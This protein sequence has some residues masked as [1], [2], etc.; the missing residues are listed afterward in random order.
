[1][2]PAS[3]LSLFAVDMN[4]VA[5]ADLDGLLCGPAQLTRRNRCARVSVLVAPGWRVDALV[6]ELAA[7]GLAAG[8]GPAGSGVVEGGLVS[9]RTDFTE[10]LAALAVRWSGGT[11]KAVPSG[12]RLDGARLRLWCLAAGEPGEP[13]HSWQLR[14][15][16]HDPDCWGPV[17]SALATAGLPAALVG[18]RGAG[19]AYRL[20]GARRLVRLAELVGAPPDGTPPGQWP[21]GPQ[22]VPAVDSAPPGDS[23]PLR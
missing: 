9:V 12:L 16:T 15:G 4:P 17:G 1:M 22:A 5:I 20:T 10:R 8:A 7:R 13:E 2:V 23:E 14:L 21:G 6:G 18:P 3:Q 19:P 11:G